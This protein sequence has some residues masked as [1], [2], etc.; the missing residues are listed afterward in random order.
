MGKYRK[1]RHEQIQYGLYLSYI[2]HIISSLGDVAVLR[3]Y[4]IVFTAV[5]QL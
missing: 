5:F 2:F 3:L 4:R 1:E